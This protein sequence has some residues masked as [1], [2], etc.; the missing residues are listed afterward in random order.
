[1]RTTVRA[2]FTRDMRLRGLSPVT[3]TDRLEMVGRLGRWLEP[4]PLLDAT[5]YDLARWQRQF[6]GLAP[7]SVDI[8]VRHVQAF[9]RWAHERR[10]IAEDPALELIRPKLHRG[11]PHPTPAA[12]LR[13][14]FACTSGP[15]RVAYA[16]AA[17]AGARCGEI[18]R[19]DAADLDLTPCRATALL[20]GKGG[21][22]RV[23]PLLAP[24]VAEL[25]T[26]G[27]PRSGAILRHHGVLPYTPDNLSHASH[28]HLQRLRVGTTLHSMRHA[29]A[30]DTFRSTRDLLL[31][32]E[33]LGHA[34]V[35]TTQIY[36][37]PDM[38]DLH[39]RLAA[40]AA[41][42]AGMLTPRKLRAVS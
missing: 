7:A 13:M 36:A 3:I 30:T 35:A 33:L 27:L 41:T 8:Y 34:S 37:A 31:V 1:M 15:L 26:Y 14:I 20:T 4:T 25:L 16:L 38:D 40:V 42:A 6:A 19:L 29:F 23:V 22:D 18:A 12:Q 39:A 21:K 17:F 24:V 9:Y 10:L 11:R 28:R 32:A 2:D 5:S